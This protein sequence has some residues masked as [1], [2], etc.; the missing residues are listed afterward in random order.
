MT[1]GSCRNLQAARLLNWQTRPTGTVQPTRWAPEP[2]CCA[3]VLR[4]AGYSGS[5]ELRH[6]ASR[7]IGGCNS[8]L[9]RVK[10]DGMQ[11]EPLCP[12][13]VWGWSNRRIEALR[14][15]RAISGWHGRAVV[16][17]VVVSVVGQ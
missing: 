13:T 16:A 4:F 10:P 14:R 9:D 1:Q 15:A 2:R 12:G 11:W 3:R 5:P 17:R 6:V 8:N 7:V